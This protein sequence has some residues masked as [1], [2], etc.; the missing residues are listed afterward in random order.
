MSEAER[1]AILDGVKILVGAALDA[2]RGEDPEYRTL[3][4]WWRGTSIEAAFRKSHQAEAELARLYDPHEVAAEEL[5]TVARID[6]ALNRD[7]PVRAEARRLLS[8]PPGAQ[9]RALLSKLI[10]VGHEAVDGSHARLRNF[11]NVLLTASWCIAVLVLAFSAVVIVNPG[12][13]PFCFEPGLAPGADGIAVAC[14]TGDDD[15]QLPAPLDVVVVGLLGLL[16]GAL[17]AAV[18][19]RNLKGT[20][21]PYD[22]PIALALLKVPAGALM[23]LGALIAIRGEFIPGLSALDS[24]EQILAYALVFG[25]AQQLLT[26]LIDRQAQG[27]LNAVPSKDAA[28][29]RPQL[30]VTTR[31]EAL[32]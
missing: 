9:K 32:A 6:V 17:S 22:V 26:G 10:Q 1:T 19:I 5:P 24:Q 30:S 27:L 18:S 16:G 8:M 28:Q 4:S 21:T 15:G 14:P 12:A 2:A 7:D 25:Y 29:D 31:Q 13:V 20:A 23:A 3:R 11:R